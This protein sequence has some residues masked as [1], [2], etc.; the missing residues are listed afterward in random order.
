MST[1]SL[2]MHEICVLFMDDRLVQL[3]NNILMS[4]MNDWLMNLT[5]LLLVNDR[6]MM[7]VDYWL[8]MLMHDVLVMFMNHIFMMFMDHISMRLANDGNTSIT[9]NLR[10]HSVGFNNSLIHMSFQNSWLFMSDNCSCPSCNKRSTQLLDLM[11]HELLLA[12]QM[13]LGR[14]K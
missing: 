6:L 3:M 2:L 1:L 13:L 10:C 7:L 12:S 5:N 8:M 14:R 11:A 4:L 9:N